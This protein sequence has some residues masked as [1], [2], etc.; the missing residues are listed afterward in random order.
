MFNNFLPILSSAYTQRI[1]PLGVGV[2]C[3]LTCFLLAGCTN[4]GN[5]NQAI[6]ADCW[7]EVPAPSLTTQDVEI[8]GIAAVSPDDIWTVG[9]QI[10]PD[11]SSKT[12]TLHWDGKEWSIVPSPNE[13]GGAHGKNHLYAVAARAPDDVWAVGAYSIT[14]GN[15]RNVAMHW[16]GK[17]WRLVETPSPG[18]LENGLNDVDI[19]AP[20]DVWAVGTGIS[21]EAH[22]PHMTIL[23]WDGISWK[24][25]PQP[26]HSSH[27]LLAVKALSKHD[28]WAAGTDVLHWDGHEWHIEATTAG[29]LGGYFDG[30]AATGPDD[31]W[32]TGNDGNEAVAIHWDGKAWSG[33]NTPKLMDGPFPHDIDAVGPHSVW[34]AGEYSDDPSRSLPM[35]LR[36][37]GSAWRLV[38]NPIAGRSARLQGLTVADGTLW[39][40]GSQRDSQG[41]RLLFL[42][43][44]SLDV[45]P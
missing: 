43:R 1:Y 20:N 15:F 14:A 18:L 17:E 42:R 3:L 6:E 16:N 41:T 21:D 22:D 40:A 39:A 10:N 11:G 12:L 4:D 38:A 35:L 28:I 34:I 8:G 45:C 36:W 44:S 24:Q 29:E 23:H 31:V 5:S 2:V 25:V 9:H 32:I 27:N 33:G 26:E 37:D 7:A 19:L 30:I 13:A